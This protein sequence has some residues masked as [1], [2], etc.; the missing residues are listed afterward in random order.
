MS[1]SSDF[2]K[3]DISQITTYQSGI[4]QSTAHRVINR[5]VSDYLLEYGLTAMHWFTVGIIY[6]AGEK[7]IRIS[8]LT[9]KLQTTTPFVTNTITLLESKGL[10]QKVAHAGDSRIKLVSITPGFIPTVE[11]IEKGLREYMRKA[12][13]AESNV[14]REELQAYIHVLYKI[15]GHS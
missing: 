8:D 9:K 5:I 10:V 7:G 1:S 11:E 14:T 12:L 15:I 6:D 13:Y 2:A 3:K 4:A